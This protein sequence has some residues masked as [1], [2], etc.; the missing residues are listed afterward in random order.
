LEAV[1]LLKTADTGQIDWATVLKPTGFNTYMGF[2]IRRFS[3]T[4]QATAPM[5]VKFEFGTGQNGPSIKMTVGTATDGAGTFV[6]NTTST[7]NMSVTGGTIVN[8]TYVSGDGGRVSVA[9]NVGG[10]ATYKQMAFS[11]ERLKDSD[12]TP[13][14]NGVSICAFGYS[15]GL[16]GQQ[17]LPAGGGLVFPTAE[18]S[19]PMCA[20]PPSGVTTFAE[21]IGFFPIHPYLGFA[22]NPDLGFVIFNNAEMSGVGSIV[23]IN[24]YGVD[25]AYLICGDIGGPSAVNGATFTLGVMMRYE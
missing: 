23:N 22:G 21:N 17:I 18:L 20:F 7:K 15:G 10:A 3:D 19:R 11:I 4:L 6:G 16:Y 14:A 8:P 2:E 24:I 12:G 25:H 13:N 1:G 5:F 9:F